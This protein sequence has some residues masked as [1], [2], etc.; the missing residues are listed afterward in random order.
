MPRHK[1]PD[2]LTQCATEAISLGMSYGDYMAKYHPPGSQVRKE[3]PKPRTG[4]KHTRLYCG[5]EFTQYD[6]RPR[7]YCCE[8][9]RIAYNDQMERERKQAQREADNPATPRV[10]KEKPPRPE[11]HCAVCGEIISEKWHSRYC[12]EQC[13]YKARLARIKEKNRRKKEE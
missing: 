13:A 6:R 11:K 4:T 7:K 10:K 8:E 9:H 12:C 1:A 2:R 5:A 3:P